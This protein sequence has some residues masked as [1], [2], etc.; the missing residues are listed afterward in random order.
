[1][2]DELNLREIDAYAK[3]A[4]DD[5]DE[6]ILAEIKDIQIGDFNSD[7]ASQI[8]QY[9]RVKILYP[10]RGND[11]EKDTMRILVRIIEILN[12]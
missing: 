4:I 9:I 12:D 8:E 7:F 5:L 6:S 10:D 1:M 11:L 3:D 2:K